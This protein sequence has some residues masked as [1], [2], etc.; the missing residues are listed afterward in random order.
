MKNTKNTLF[1]VT[2][3]LAAGLLASLLSGCDGAGPGEGV[4]AGDAGRPD[5][6]PSLKADA[7][8]ADAVPSSDARATSCPVPTPKFT[9]GGLITTKPAYGY[10]IVE[11]ESVP[12]LSTLAG[13]GQPTNC[14][15]P[16][17]G[18]ASGTG[19]AWCYIPTQQVGGLY[20]L[21]SSYLVCGRTGDEI[22]ASRAQPATFGFAICSPSGKFLGWGA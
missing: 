1:V 10:R 20:Y 16:V 8:R 21:T 11:A 13:G 2:A 3:A 15:D 17:D 7:G 14:S 19:Q 18:F 22:V 5:A 12:C 6:E 4:E 9:L